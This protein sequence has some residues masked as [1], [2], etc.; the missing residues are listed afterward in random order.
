[1]ELEGGFVAPQDSLQM[2]LFERKTG[3][4][5]PSLVH[6]VGQQLDLPALVQNQKYLTASRFHSCD[7]IIHQVLLEAGLPYA[8]FYHR[9]G[10]NL[11]KLAFW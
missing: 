10:E 8:F 9:I 11:G 7:A 6:E 2:F 4:M 1:M 5:C 3:V